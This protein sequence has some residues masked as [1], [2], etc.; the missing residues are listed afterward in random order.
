MAI[1]EST[2]GRRS[3][4]VV[5]ELV[6]F[7]GLLLDRFIQQASQQSLLR[8]LFLGGRREVTGQM[9]IEI[10]LDLLRFQLRAVSGI[11]RDLLRDG[12]AREL[13]FALN[14]LKLLRPGTLRTSKNTSSA[15]ETSS[16]PR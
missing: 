6:R 15:S 11:L 16:G 5:E 4:N 10:A 2:L 7:P 9:A 13:V 12:R 8:L 14:L 1:P 3:T